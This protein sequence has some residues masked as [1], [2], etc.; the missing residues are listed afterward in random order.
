MRS[1]PT[2]VGKT[3]YP[4][5]YLATRPVHPHACGENGRPGG[6]PCGGKPVHPH[7]CGENYSQPSNMDVPSGPPPRLWGKQR[8]YIGRAVR[9]RSTPTPVGKT[10]K[11]MAATTSDAVHPH[12][13]GENIIAISGQATLSRSTPTPV[14]KTSM[15]RSETGGSSVHPHACGENVS[16]SLDVRLFAGPPPRLWGKRRRYVAR[17]V[18]RGP[19][20]RLWGKLDF[21]VAIAP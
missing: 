3:D 5:S 13:C 19:P 2:P 10:T 16:S 1:T 20:P 12:A 18:A 4:E 11:S 8:V 15:N 17:P 9:A 21:T 6:S 14:G 7:A